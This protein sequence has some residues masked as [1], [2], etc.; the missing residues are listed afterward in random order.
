MC[1]TKAKFPSE[2][3]NINSEDISIL[4]KRDIAPYLCSLET[5]DFP[6][7]LSEDCQTLAKLEKKMSKIDYDL[8]VYSVYIAR[9]WSHL[10]TA[11]TALFALK[12]TQRRAENW[13]FEDYS[14]HCIIELL[15]ERR[16]GT[17]LKAASRKITV[18]WGAGIKSATEVTQS[19][20]YVYI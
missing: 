13:F 8:I 1:G 11:P 14:E 3:C 19:V 7:V 2:W 12:I 15:L 20:M 5:T 10:G 6:E 18:N 16:D 4:H 17:C 9:P